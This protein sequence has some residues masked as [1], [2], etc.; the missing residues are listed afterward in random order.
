MKITHIGG[1]TALIEV[2]GWHLLTDPTFDAPGRRYA[3]GWGTSSTKVSGPAVSLASLGRIDAVLLTHDH[4]GDNLDDLG[5]A[6]LPDVS[7]VITTSSGAGRL[8]GNATGLAPWATTRL[9]GEDPGSS[10]EIQA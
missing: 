6:M 1:P 2:G 9:S 7:R 10:T 3:F 8:G 4:H 5:R